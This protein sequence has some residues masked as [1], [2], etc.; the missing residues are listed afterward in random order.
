MESLGL[1]TDRD[2]A[3]MTERFGGVEYS[4]TKRMQSFLPEV[5]GKF[6]AVLEN[7]TFRKCE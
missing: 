3:L 2:S 5:T 7:N 1:R 6:S 4:L